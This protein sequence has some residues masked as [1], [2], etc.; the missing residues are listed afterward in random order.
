M[1][2]YNPSNTQGP[3]TLCTI[4]ISLL[5]EILP[6]PISHLGSSCF[7]PIWLSIGRS[8]LFNA[9]QKT[10]KKPREAERERERARQRER[11]RMEHV[12][13]TVAWARAHASIEICGEERGREA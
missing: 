4:D 3:S 10:R 11:D 5:R 1:N 8:P 6:V 12:S 9:V 7:A 13:R 2:K